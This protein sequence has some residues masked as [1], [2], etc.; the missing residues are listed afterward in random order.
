M[1]RDAPPSPGSLYEYLIVAIVLQNAVIRR[2]I[3]MMQT[4]FEAYGT[5]AR[6]RRPGA[7]LLLGASGLDGVTEEEL[8][9]LKVGYAGQVDP[10][11]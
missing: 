11:A 7:V 9:Q 1:A 5:A 8:R 6:L 2:S 4:L 10:A 3:Q